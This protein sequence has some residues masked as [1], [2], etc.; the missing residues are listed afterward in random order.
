[1]QDCAQLIR[2]QLAYYDQGF[3]KSDIEALPNIKAC[4]QKII[5]SSML[6]KNNRL[7]IHNY[8]TT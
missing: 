2:I 1:M 7:I 8:T 4:L 3:E 5:K 6:I